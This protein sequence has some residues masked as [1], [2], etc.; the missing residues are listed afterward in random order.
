[1]KKIIL[2]IVALSG[3][4]TATLAQSKDEVILVERKTDYRESLMFGLRAGANYANVYDA[5]GE[6]FKNDAKFG[7]AGGFFIVIPIGKFLGVQPEALYSQKGFHATGR[8]L[9]GTYDFTRTTNYIDIPLFVAIK[10]SKFFTVLVGPQYS[11]LLSQSDV[12]A[13]GSTSSEQITEFKNEN[14]RK[15]TLSIAGGVDV[16]ISHVVVGARAGWDIT[17][18][19]GNG[20]STTPRYKN[21]WL[22]ATLG[23]RF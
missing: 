22:Q 8:I 10:P 2:G 18:N 5:Q 16:N 14:I 9:G 13:N 6:E 11:Y 23:F 12:F 21:S 19:N 4:T 17:N 20:T 1:M 15:N 3:I 7:F